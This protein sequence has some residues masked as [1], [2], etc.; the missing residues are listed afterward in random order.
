MAVS[1]PFNLIRPGCES[2]ISAP[3]DA[4]AIGSNPL[5]LF[6]HQTLLTSDAENTIEPLLQGVEFGAFNLDNRCQLSMTGEAL[7]VGTGQTNEAHR[8]ENDQPGLDGQSEQ[9]AL[10]LSPIS[11]TL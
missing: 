9:R 1:L 7:L 8:S 3:D 4:K 6:A 2:R 11:L 10:K 5:I